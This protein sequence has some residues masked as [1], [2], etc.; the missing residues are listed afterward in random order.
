MIY[1][2]KYYKYLFVLLTSFFL[3]FMIVDAKTAI[4]TF[5]EYEEQAQKLDLVLLFVVP[6]TIIVI[7]GIYYYI[8]NK[9]IIRSLR[10]K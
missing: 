9:R 6:I 7:G 4:T 5:E 10:L 8:K 1:I 3:V 2:K